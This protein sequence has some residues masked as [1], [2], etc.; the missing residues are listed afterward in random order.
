MN[1]YIRMAKTL[2]TTLAFVYLLCSGVT[3]AINFSGFFKY[4]GYFNYFF[5]AI[6][7]YITMYRYFKMQEELVNYKLKGEITSANN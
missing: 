4:F 1:Y 2:F 7:L 3:I 6:C 5:S